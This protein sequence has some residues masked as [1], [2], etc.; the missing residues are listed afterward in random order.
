MQTQGTLYDADGLIEKIG[1]A[2]LGG[3]GYNTEVLFLEFTLDA[4]TLGEG[5]ATVSFG[6]KFNFSTLSGGPTTADGTMG[7]IVANSLT[8]T[9]TDPT[10]A[11]PQPEFA[12]AFE[13]EYTDG[14]RASA[15]AEL[16]LCMVEGASFDITD[17]EDSPADQ[18]FEGV[19][20]GL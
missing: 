1:G 15:K 3:L 9:V 7:V 16:I 13:R 5:A 4:A 17:P 14:T 10:V 19:L 11:P 12:L 8:F 20:C 6:D 2:Y 18:W